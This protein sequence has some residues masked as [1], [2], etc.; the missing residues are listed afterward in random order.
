MLCLAY[1]FSPQI[2]LTKNEKWY[3]RLTKEVGDETP[4]ITVTSY[5]VRKKMITEFQNAC[6]D[7]LKN[8]REARSNP[9]ATGE[10]SLRA[11]LDNIFTQTAA[12]FNRTV[13]VVGEAQRIVAGRPDFT[14]SVND[15]PI[16]Y[17]EAE[18][19]N[20]NL[21][22]LTG[23][24]KAQN[25]RFRANLDNFLLTNHLEFR[26]YVG[27]DCVDRAILPAP[28]ETGRITVTSTEAE[29]LALLLERFPLNRL[30]ERPGASSRSSDA[31]DSNRGFECA[32]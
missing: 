21:D 12:I 7:Y 15:L 8:L 32:Q 9:L 23:H 24:A 4:T 16:G 3:L 6:L 22:Q 17:I 10:L 2:L 31:P 11:V 26:L 19:Y 20:V 18:A 29:K 30:S 14:V 1:T 27:G 5:K 25:D 13:Q 28:P